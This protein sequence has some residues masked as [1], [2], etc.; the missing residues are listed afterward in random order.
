MTIMYVSKTVFHSN[1]ALLLRTV[2]Y[3][4]ITL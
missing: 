4:V 1:L 2:L 3:C